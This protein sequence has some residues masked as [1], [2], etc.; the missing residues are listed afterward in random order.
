MAKTSFYSGSGLTNTEVDT[1]ESYV[2]E[3]KDWAIKLTDP[4]ADGEYSA[5]F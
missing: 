4:V 1:L 2:Q 5:K 3:A